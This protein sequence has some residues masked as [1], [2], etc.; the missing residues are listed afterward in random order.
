[1][2]DSWI[3]PR[4]RIPF[5]GIVAMVIIVAVVAIFIKTQLAP[6]FPASDVTVTDEQQNIGG[7]ASASFYGMREV[8]LSKKAYLQ[9]VLNT[10][11]RGLTFTIDVSGQ[12]MTIAQGE[13]REEIQLH[14][15]DGLMVAVFEYEGVQTQVG[16]DPIARTLK[17][18]EPGKSVAFTEVGLSELLVYQ[19][20]FTLRNEQ[21]L[22]QFSPAGPQAIISSNTVAHVPLTQSGSTYSGVW[23]TDKSHPISIDTEKKVATIEELF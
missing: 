7:R 20:T 8:P 12:Y 18:N 19:G 4:T 23:R 3:E 21:Y 5:T 16:V 14:D 13:R 9:G 22:F 1:M 11:T 10:P 6:F 2:T 17:M 15:E